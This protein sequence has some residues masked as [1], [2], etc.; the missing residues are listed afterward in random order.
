MHFAEWAIF[1]HNRISMAIVIGLFLALGVAYTAW[2]RG[3]NSG[4]AAKVFNGK[5]FV[6]E[7]GQVVRLASIQAPNAED[8]PKRAIKR[9]GQPLAQESRFTLMR[10]VINQKVKLVTSKQKYDRKKRLVAQVYL[11][12]GTW[13]QGQML[14]AGMAMVYGFSDSREMLP[15]MLAA[16]EKARVAKRGIWALPYYRVL[17][18]EEA[19]EGMDRYR[20]VEGVV[21]Q[22]S[23]TKN[24][25]YLNFG[26][27]RDTD[28]T[29][30]VAGRDMK[31][32]KGFDL[33]ALAGKRVRVRGWIYGRGGPM[34]ELS[35]PE[36]IELLPKR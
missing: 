2:G 13:V 21:R 17:Q 18:A 31:A 23:A 3:T 4:V 19:G 12:D 30:S 36:Q 5:S 8:G 9:P 34:I 35:V 27:D 28:F 25:V 22:V 1:L 14:E 7:G 24:R 20:L 6:M 15:Q 10:M 32:F 16:E 26:R 33:A 11:G 29:A